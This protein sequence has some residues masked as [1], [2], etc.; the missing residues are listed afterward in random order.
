MRGGG[1]LRQM[2]KHIHFDL[3]ALNGMS[4]SPAYGSQIPSVHR[5]AWAEGADGTMSSAQAR[6]STNALPIKQP[7]PASISLVNKLSE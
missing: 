7:T 6:V 4:D 5:M 1:L 2:L 3:S